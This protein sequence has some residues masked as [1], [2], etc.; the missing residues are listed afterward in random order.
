MATLLAKIKIRAGGEAQ[1]ESAIATLVEKTLASEPNAIRYEY[2]KAQAPN[3]WYALLA[4][5][6]KNA[7]FAHQ[8][9]DYHRD[10]GYGDLVEDIELEF[11]DPVATASPLPRTVNTPL[12]D[13]APPNITEWEELSP[14]VQAD[15]WTGRA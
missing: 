9:A 12:P 2:W 5:A 4:F 6:D 15:W 8:D 1:W 11:V 14:V 3:T 13:D 10:G 7:F